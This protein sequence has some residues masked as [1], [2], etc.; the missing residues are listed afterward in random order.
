MP[1]IVVIGAQWG[2]EG[3]G[4]VVDFL[5]ARARMVVRYSGGNN[6]GHTVINQHGE[7]RLHLVPVGIFHPQVS[8]IIAN[9]VVVDP[10]ALL[11][12]LDEVRRAGVDTGHLYISDRA[13]LVMPYH[14]LLDGL[15]EESR[16]KGSLG[17]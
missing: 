7:F 12:E 3:K 9:G 4:K 5:A 15:E 10:G 11:E 6:A 2:D 16:G 17:T 1:A 13:N 14:R 8:C